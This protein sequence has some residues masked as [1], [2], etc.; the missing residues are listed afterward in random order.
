LYNKR[1]QFFVIIYNNPDFLKNFYIAIT[2]FLFAAFLP[3]KGT[4]QACNL[5]TASYESAESRCAA[6]GSITVNATGGS[7][8]YQYKV[9]GPVTTNYTSSSLIVGLAAGKYL[10]FVK[11]IVTNCL[12]AQDSVTVAGSYIT[13]SFTLVSTAVTCPNGNNGTIT[14]TGT[15]N[16]RSPFSY[17]IVA[18]SASGTGTVSAS[19][20]FSG[21]LSGNYLIQLTDSCGAIQTRSIAVDNFLWFIN[22]YTVTKLG[23]DSIAVVM[24]LKDDRG[25]STPH[26]VFNGFTYG[27][28]VIPGDT[29]WF[30]T[31]SFQYYKGKKH[32]VKL[33]AKDACGN[34][35][36]V[37]WSDNAIPNVNSSINISNRACS[38][39]T[40]RV[41]G[42]VNL[43]NPNYCI[44]NS[45]NVVISCNTT[46]VFTGLPYGSYCIRISDTCYD[47]TIT[48]CFTVTRPVP[49]TDLN[50]DIVRTCNSFTALI[51]GQVNLSNPN[52]CLYGA[53]NVLILC[54]TTGVFSGLPF[55][56]YCIRVVNDPACYDTT[57]T[58]CF[59][60]ARP[61]PRLGVDVSIYNRTCTTFTAEI[62][63]TADWNSPQFCLYTPA[64]VVIICNTT[65]VFNNLPYGTYCI[66]ATNGA[67]CYD[68]TITR[69][70]T[71][72]RPTP[73]IDDYAVISNKT[74]TT[75]DATITGQT[76]V[77]NPQYCL[78]N[79]SNVLISCNATGIFTGIPYGSYCIKM[80]NDAACY[81]T[82][83]TRCFTEAGIPVDISLSARRSCTT[84][85]TTDMRVRFD[86]GTPAYTVA[87]YSPAGVLLQSASASGSTYTFFSLPGLVSPAKYKVIVTD[88]CGRKDSGLVSSN[89]SRVNRVVSTVIKCPSAVWANGSAD[90]VIDINDNNIGGNIIPKIIM[91]NGQTVSV[92]ATTTV[93]YVYTFSNLGPATYI[94]DTYI[95]DCNKH[96]F[97]TVVVRAYQF[98][99]LTSSKAFQCD[100]QSYT[101]TASVTGGRPPFMYEIFGSVPAVP[102]IV[103][104]PQ[105]SP[106][107]TINNG[108]SYSLIR[109]RVVDACG[110]ASLYDA[111]VLP[112]SNFLVFTDSL[113][114]FNH[115]LTLRVDSIANA[116]YSW[117][118]R[119]IPNDSILVGAGP[120]YYVP[121][122]TPS[123]TGRYFCIISINNGCVTKVANY[124]V[125]GW[126]GN[127]LPVPVTLHG[128]KMDNA[129]R[130]YWQADKA[131]SNKYHLQRSAN[132]LSGFQTIMATDYAGNGEIFY[133]DINPPLND[134][135]YRLEI[136]GKDGGV[137]YS[138]IVLLKKSVTGISIYPNPINSVLYIS[139]NSLQSQ[140]FSISISSLAGQ[141]LFDK[142]Y[143]DIQDAVLTI[144]RKSG[145]TSGMYL[146]T[147]TFLRSNEKQV[148]KLVY[149]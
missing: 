110:N 95:S 41:R 32:S 72:M 74:C 109:L 84:I 55:G 78:Y 112:L 59:T 16:G 100:N 38:T 146:L 61:V 39:F 117:Y 105:A 87:L 34:I 26:A 148:F 31:N 91:K 58:R 88:F 40:A 14:V 143:T 19:G 97:D 76:N 92:N 73:V 62:T 119:V 35:Q 140:S 125:S 20:T 71:V 80:Q 1:G 47:T 9:S 15:S 64:H 120:S 75:F 28:S 4:S 25:N 56:T 104:A 18:P 83:I 81:D 122:L 60:V 93:G 131:S 142:T 5:L 144:P 45:S 86:S 129:N 126:C 12:Y 46:G 33:F 102:S 127:V 138:N 2:A 130:L 121:N 132:S 49:A 57:I 13:P 69:C 147:I 98:P 85:G 77:S 21:L 133:K 70:F 114:C 37:V 42:Q 48:R 103:T 89:V 7:G 66:E 96:V 137:D 27:A 136:V 115:S 108:A 3:V 94:F 51:T 52:Y 82:V 134:S 116:T 101:V 17:K 43:T 44:Y 106:V 53:N 36:M 11:D 145:I 8:N 50:V 139:V 23:C 123:D 79:N 10:V 113:E 149:R 30:T 22:S 65:G 54:N 99:G 111:N 90:V 24:I 68:T 67:G 135:Y 124:K 128:E 6:T 118:K 29:S 141:R 63:D 107:F